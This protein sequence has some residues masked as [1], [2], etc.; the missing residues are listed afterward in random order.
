MRE[1]GLLLVFMLILEISIDIIE[2]FAPVSTQAV[3]ILNPSLLDVYDN[4]SPMVIAYMERNKGLVQR[5]EVTAYRTISTNEIG[6]VKQ[7]EQGSYV[8][9]M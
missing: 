9:G 7:S 5:K 1:G 8:P 2:V 3:V 6:K 4:A